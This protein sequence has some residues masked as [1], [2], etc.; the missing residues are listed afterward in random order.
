M[1]NEIFINTNTTW[2]MFFGSRAKIKNSVLP[3]LH[4]NG[5]I[6]QRTKT[7]T[8]LGIKL[9]EQLTLE[10]HAGVL[11]KRVSEKIYQLSKIRSYISKRVVLLI[12]KNMILPIL[13][14]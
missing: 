1:E 5:D 14:Y 12:Y 3:D 6:I 9:D 4:I 13:E 8:Y 7:Y 2:V 11:I 10:T